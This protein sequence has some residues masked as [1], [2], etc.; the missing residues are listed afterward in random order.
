MDA[1]LGNDHTTWD[2]VIDAV[3]AV[4]QVC[5][6]DRANVGSSDP[7]PTPRTSVDVVADLE[8]LLRAAGVASPYV[9]VGHSWGGVNVR[10][11]AEMHPE[12]IAGLVLVDG[13]P[14]PG[15]D[16][17]ICQT[18]KADCSPSQNPSEYPEGLDLSKSDEELR[19][20]G[21]LPSV[22]LVVLAATHH[23]CDDPRP[24][25]CLRIEALALVIQRET[26]AAVPG[27]QLV[28]ATGSGHYI[29]NDRPDLV[30]EAIEAV[31]RKV[32]GP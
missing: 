26:A 29:Q 1:G 22:P 23:E 27:G 18:N 15:F 21:S 8:A 16:R 7:A 2:P 19:A 3:S 6:Y 12:E 30:V 10:L 9:L 4:S 5:T 14:A 31:V 17:R 13:S 11:F 24:G 20:G 25:T 28:I 32:R